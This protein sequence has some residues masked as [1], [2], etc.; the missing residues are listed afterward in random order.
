MSFNPDLNRQTQVCFN[1]TFIGIYIVGK[2]SSFKG[3][4]SFLN[5]C[6]KGGDQIFLIPSQREKLIK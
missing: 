1:N 4:L 5:F 6:K 2:S 3:G